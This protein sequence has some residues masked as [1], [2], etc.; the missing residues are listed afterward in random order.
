MTLDLGTEDGQR[1]FLDLVCEADIV[2]ENFA[3]HIIGNLNLDYDTLRGVKP[4]LIMLAM[5]AYG[6]SGPYSPYGGIGGTA[7]PMSGISML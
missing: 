6:R 7:E 4:D 2:A 1:L 3:S 5:P